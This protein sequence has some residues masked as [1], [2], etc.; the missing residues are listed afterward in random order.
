M[1]KKKAILVATIGTRDLAF[2]VSSQEWLNLGNSY[3]ADSDSISEQALV[4]ME[5]GLEKCDFRFL[6]EYLGENWQKYA[7][8]LQPIILGQLLQDNCKQLKGIYLVA[9]DQSENVKFRDKDTLYS[10][11]IIQQWVE[12]HYQIPTEVILQGAE[13]GNPADFEAM[14]RWWKQTWQYISGNRSENSRILLCVKGGVGAF[15]EAGRVTALSLF[16]EDTFFYDFIKDDELNRLGKPSRYTV[17][18]Q[19]KN[20]LWDRK[21]QEALALLKR[22]D[23]EAVNKVLS[24]YFAQP[25]SDEQNG[26][27]IG[28]IEK[29]IKSAI[30][31]N[32]GDFEN[33]ASSLG[34]TALT[35][36]R[37]WWW[38]GYEAA[39]LGV[40][41]FKQGNTIEAMFHSFRAVEGLMS[42]W[43]IYSFSNHITR[44][45][46]FG[47]I[48][49]GKVP[50]VNKSIAR[51]PGLQTY[52]NR[53]KTHWL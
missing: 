25:E 47:D 2:R 16:G 11:Y 4:Q 40:I 42:E 44:R 50:L 53:R 49:K 34:E 46:R 27:L 41:R 51:L 9:T 35:R 17:P 33:F 7:E 31:W 39:Y 14:F 22:Y 10:A 36:S 48:A 19:G 43:A 28:R 29:L 1:S 15:S 3:V 20:Y 6:T 8:Q 5:L 52:R 26:G 18:F 37:Q 12:K 24:A 38:I 21:Q 23:Y 13:G 32:H 45:D 30:L